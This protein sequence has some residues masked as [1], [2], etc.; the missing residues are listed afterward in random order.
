MLEVLEDRCVPSIVVNNPTDMPVAGEIDL[1]QAIAQANTDGGAETITFDSTVFSIPQTIDLSGGQLD[2]SD[3]TGL[4]TI[5]GPNVGVTVNGGG[6]SR[7]FEVDNLVSASI[8]GLTITGGNAGSGNGGGV[9]NYGSLALTDC[10]VSGNSASGYYPGGFGGGISSSNATL[11]LTNCTVSGNSA[12]YCG[13]VCVDGGTAKLVN[14]TVSGNSAQAAGGLLA[15]YG[16]TATLINCTISGNSA[17]FPFGN[18]YGGLYAQY[19]SGGTITLG[20]TIVAGNTP[21]DVGD[22]GFGTAFISEGNNLIGLT[23]GA[24]GWVSSDLTGTFTPLNPVLA[25]LGNYGG[26]TQ[27]MPLLPGSPAIAAG[28]T[29]LLPAGLTSDQR[30]LPRVVNGGV[31]IGAFESEGFTVTAL[32]GSTPQTAQIGTAFA[33]PLGVTVTANNPVEPVNG[34]I[35]SFVAHAAANGASALLSASSAVISGGQ[36][37]VTAAPDNAD[38]SYQV[39]ASAPALVSFNLTNTGPIYSTLSVNTTSDSLAPGAGL[40]SLR[41]AIG[42]ANFD[43]SGNA[44]ITF[45]KKVFAKPQ[46]ITLSGGQLELSNA[47]ETESIIGP[48]A[49]VTINAGGASRVF[50]V[51]QPVTASISGATITGGNP[52][53]GSGVQNDGSLTLTGCT[54]SGNTAG[55]VNNSGTLAMTHCTVSNNTTGAGVL[56]SGTLGMTSC[57]VSDNTNSTS[58][59]FIFTN[60]GGVL[61][62]GGEATLGDCTIDGNSAGFGGGLSVIAGTVTLTNCTLSDNSATGG[63]GVG[64]FVFSQATI[65]LTSCKL[66][67]NS[68]EGFFGGGGMLTASFATGTTATLTNCTLSGNS[69]ASAGG[70]LTNLGGV[71]AALTNCTVT[72]NSADDT[73]GG[74][75]NGSG[76]VIIGGATPTLTLTGC[77]VSN[78][79]AAAGG[80]GVANGSK[81]TLNACAVSGNSAS[82]GGGIYNQGGTLN[83][84]L[85]IVASNKA[86]SSGGGI[87]TTGGSLTISASLIYANR[88]S[89]SATA[90]GGG[91][92]CEN[93]LLSL[94]GCTVNGNQAAG[95]TALGGGIY[96][97]DSTV[98]LDL[99]TV[100]GNQAHGTTLGEGGGIYSEG[101]TL[102]LDFAFVLGNTATTAYDNIF[103]G[104]SRRQGWH[105]GRIIVVSIAIRVCRRA[106]PN[107][108]RT[109]T[110]TRTART[111]PGSQ[112]QRLNQ[113]RSLVSRAV[114]PRAYRVAVQVAT[115]VRL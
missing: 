16:G 15:E 57:T 18:A 56:S 62:A 19:F 3:T 68:A 23:N 21:V 92:A 25:P 113:L 1:R 51:D 75:A 48:S 45:D 12:S 76:E 24:T 8:S 90:L 70:G 104:P 88:V 93:T 50:L 106:N 99:C 86:S 36:A 94:T 91:I 10:T 13:G 82:T 98:N 60:G 80:G 53:Y 66:I 22:G 67:D 107:A 96:A 26:P 47:T 41:E 43:R 28:N 108:R 85:C 95:A 5:I 110:P 20:N 87:S 61:I 83:M 54:V 59:P 103:S 109:D 64:A 114:D 72:G 111:S 33:R 37:S 101:S 105:I 79:S 6:S 38:G 9:Q 81:A 112:C 69:S 77:L 14:C 42:F 46:T 65:T 34:G 7:V 2:L 52:T 84:N 29:A 11:S 97:F 74:L 35:V 78:N 32:A 100:S 58:A 89:S 4:E 63:G 115:R 30:G 40:L 31:D 49:G 55:G 102:T 73:G 71:A 27:T 17:N 44:K 39:I